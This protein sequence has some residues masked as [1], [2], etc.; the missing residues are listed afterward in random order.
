MSSGR[1]VQATRETTMNEAEIDYGHGM[2]KM[3]GDFDAETV[4]GF[5]FQHANQCFGIRKSI[6]GFR[7]I[8]ISQAAALPEPWAKME[9]ATTVLKHSGGDTIVWNAKGEK[10]KSEWD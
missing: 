2:A 8:S 3:W 10:I 6:S 5:F 7:L 1:P 4:R 9:G